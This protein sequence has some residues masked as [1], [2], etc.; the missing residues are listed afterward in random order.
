MRVVVIFYTVEP[1]PPQIYHLEH[2]GVLK[3]YTDDI[4]H[5]TQKKI[6]FILFELKDS[7]CI[8]DFS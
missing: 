8:G 1:R 4:R 2:K 3:K 5:F 7:N 6:K